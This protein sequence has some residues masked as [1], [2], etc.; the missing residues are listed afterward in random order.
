MT[1]GDSVTIN[2]LCDSANGTFVTLDD[3]L[4]LTV[5]AAEF[6]DLIFTMPETPWDSFEDE[7]ARTNTAF[8]FPFQDILR[9]CCGTTRN[10]QNCMNKFFN[11]W[12]SWHL[13]LPNLCVFLRRT[14]R[15][16]IPKQGP[17]LFQHRSK[18]QKKQCPT[19]FPQWSK[20]QAPAAVNISKQAP[21]LFPHSSTFQNNLP[22]FSTMVNI[23]KTRSTLSALVKARG[24]ASVFQW[25]G[26]SNSSDSCKDEPQAICGRVE[27]LQAV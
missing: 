10:L 24:I 4:T 7:L 19:H 5:D 27:R 3:Y 2:N 26:A 15:T 18:F 17:T 8:F 20:R 21:T 1:D 16:C 14:L 23:Q 9:T 25:R 12:L 22:H 11:N 6:G 13:E